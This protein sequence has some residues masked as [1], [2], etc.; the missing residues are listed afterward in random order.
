MDFIRQHGNILLIRQINYS[1][2]RQPTP[3]GQAPTL[4][5]DGEGLI[6]LLYQWYLQQGKKLPDKIESALEELFPDWKISFN[7]SPDGRILMNVKEGEMH[8]SPTSIPDG[9]Y[10]LLV[11]LAAVELKPKIL[12]IDEIETSIHSRFIEYLIAAFKTSESTVII[13][14]HSPLVIDLVQLEDLILL[15]KEK[16]QTKVRRIKKPE[17]IRKHLLEKNITPSESWLYGNL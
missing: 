3:I 13:S 11:I 12:L 10:K 17:Q 4:T 1:K 8:L 15:E 2:I 5:E 16:Y 7:V 14:T 9:F 6:N